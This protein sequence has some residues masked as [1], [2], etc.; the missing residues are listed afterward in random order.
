VK[1][2]KAELLTRAIFI[3]IWQMLSVIFIKWIINL[4]YGVATPAITIS[5]IGA[6]VYLAY[7][8]LYALRKNVKE[9]NKFRIEYKFVAVG[10]ALGA[11]VFEPTFSMFI[12]T[13]I[14]FYVIYN[15][16]FDFALYCGKS[17]F[18]KKPQ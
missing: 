12:L 18:A 7:L 8:G 10:L 14:M 17:R 15:V 9:W 3:I 13:G 6:L 2:A 5:I 4:L 11:A 1:K 16:I